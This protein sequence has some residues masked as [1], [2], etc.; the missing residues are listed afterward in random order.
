MILRVASAPLALASLARAAIFFDPAAVKHSCVNDD[1]TTLTPSVP[2]HLS[3]VD[4]TYSEQTILLKPI[5]PDA[6]I[7]D[8]G[9][10]VT[11]M[12]VLHRW[13][14]P[15]EDKAAKRGF[16]FP[17]GRSVP[18]VPGEVYGNY[19][20]S[21]GDWTR[22]PGRA[23]R[24]VEY[25]CGEAGNSGANFDAGEYLCEVTL[26][27]TSK[28]NAKDPTATDYNNAPY[29]LTYYQRDMTVRNE[30]ARFLEKNTFGPTEAEIDALEAEFQTLLAGAPA[31]SDP[32]ASPAGSPV[33][34]PAAA[35]ATDGPTGSPVAAAAAAATGSP[36]ASPV[37]TEATNTSRR[38]LQS[39]P[40]SHAEAMAQI[41]HNWISR[42][43]DPATF[44]S[45]EFSSLRAYWRRRLNAR[46]EETYRIGESGP[47]PCEA[48]SRWRKFAF[49]NFD[50]QNSKALRWG[51]SDI[52][53]A[54]QTQRGHRIT[55]ETV[56][57]WAPA[58][59]AVDLGA[60]ADGNGTN[61][62]FAPTLSPIMP[63]K[64]P[65][66]APVVPVPDATGSP[67]LSSMPTATPPPN[68]FAY[69]DM[70]GAQGTLNNQWPGR[71]ARTVTTNATG[72]V[73]EG[74]QSL[75][76]EGGTRCWY[77]RP[78]AT[79]CSAARV[80]DPIQFGDKLL[81]S[82]KIR[83]EN[84]ANQILQIYTA[85]YHLNKSPRRWALSTDDSYMVTR[86]QIPAADEWTTVTAVHTVGDDW[87]WNGEV[88]TPERCNHY[89]LRFRLSNSAASFY[90]DDV[91]VSK[92]GSSSSSDVSS[93]TETNATSANTTSE[94]IAETTA[95]TDV[96]VSTSGFFTN[97]N[98]DQG[99]QYWKYA[100]NAPTIR[101]DPD[102]NRNVMV[103]KRGRVLRQNVLPYT[104]PGKAYQFGFRS[105]I[106]G[107]DSVEMR[108]IVRMRFRNNDL[109]NGPC[110][111][112]VCNF[113]VRPLRR[114][115]RASDGWDDV[116]SQEFDM[117]NYTELEEYG[118]PDFIL[119]QL[120]AVNMDPAGELSVA[121]FEN[122]GDD[123]TD[124][125]SMSLAPSSA[126]SNLIQQ[127]IAYI[128]KYAGE[129]RTIVRAPFQMDNTGEVLA[130]DGSRE[131]QLCEV[132]EVEGLKAE[133]PNRMNF[134]INGRCSPI[135]G[136][137]PTVDLDPNFVNHTDL[138][139]LDLSGPNLT[140]D[141]I[142]ADQTYGGDWLL[143]T[144]VQDEAC[145]T[146]PSPY[147]NDYRGA[148]P[149]N[150][151][152][153]PTRFV[154]DKPV[155]AK[156]PDGTY[157]LYD[158]RLILHGNTLD[159][160][161]I[162][163]GGETVL[164]STIRSQRDGL[165]PLKYPWA[166]EYY[167]FNDQNIALCS[168]EQPNFI[169]Q[170]HCVV[171]YEENVCVKEYLD[172]SNTLV[173][174]QLVIKF[175]DGTL[176]NMHNATLVNY[177]ETTG[178]DNRR[179]F[180]A[181]SNLRWDDSVVNGNITVL[182]CVP[183]NPVSR[184]KPRPDL[185][186]SNC[187]N[188]LTDRSTAAFVHALESSNDENPY[189]RD[190][191]LWN[192]LDE[193]GCDEVD[194][195]KYGMLVMTNEGCW[196]NMHPDYMSIYDFTGYEDDHPVSTTGIAYINNWTAVGIMEYPD[197][198]PMSYFEQLK[199]AWGKILAVERY[200]YAS[201]SRV[202]QGA[203][204]GDTIV[205]DQFAD[206]ANLNGD[207]EILMEI[208]Q[209]IAHMTLANKVATNRGGGTLVCGSPNEVAP[210]PTLDDYFDVIHRDLDCIGCQD[211]YGDYAKQKVTVWTMDA[212]EGEDQLCGR[213]AWSL[214]ELLNVGSASNPDNT[215]SNLYTYDI[216]RRHCF[217]S[218]FDLLKELTF[219]SKTGEQFSFVGSTATRLSWDT[220][221][222]MNFPDENY[223]REI[224]QL[225][226][227]G[228]HEL[229]QDGTETRDEHGRVIKTYTN[230]DILSNARVMTG[231]MF[232]ARRGN[233]E[234]LFR[235]EKSRLDPLRIEVDSH[236]FFPKPAL[237]GGWIGDRYPLC[238]DLPEHHFL[239]LGAKY[240][241]R[242]SSSLPRVHY[243]PFHWDSDESIK[244]FVLDPSSGL[245]QAL[246]NAGDDGV[247]DYSTTVTLDANLQC[248]GKECRVDDLMVVQ[249]APGAFYEY[250]RQPCVQLSFYENPK[251]VITGFSP[252]IR[253]VGRRHTH[254]MCADPR[255]AVAARAC[256]DVAA[257]SRA[258]YN[259]DF[260]YHGERVKL[261][262]NLDQCMADNGTVCDPVAMKADNPLVN[263]RPTYNLPYPSQNTFFW[264][265][266]NCTQ[267]VKVRDG[268]M[269][270]IVNDPARNP[271]F[272]EDT[273]PFVDLINT[274]NYFSVIW[275][276]DNMTFEEIYPSLN[277]TCGGGACSI[278]SDDACEC[279]VTLV[280]SPAFNSLPSREG[281]LSLK[282]G[283]YD[284]ATFSAE[285]VTYSLL[286]SSDDVEAYV[287][288]DSVVI[289]ATS[290]IF[291]VVDEFGEVA[292]FKNMLSTITLGGLYEL[293][294]P[295]SFMNLVKVELRDAEYEV[296]AFLK[297]L[298]QYRSSAPFI[299]KKLIQYHGISNPSPG[300]AQRITQAFVTGSYSSNGV[301][302]GNGKFGSLKAVAAAIALDPESL[303]PVID[304]DPVSGNIR[305][306]LLKVIHF[307]RS[308][309]FQRRPHVKFRHGLFDNM[310]YKVGQLVFDPPD[311]F[312]FFA[313][314][315][316]PPGVLAETDM[317]SPESELMSMSSVVGLTTGLFSFVNY[318]LAHA[319]G[320]FGPSLNKLPDVGD[321]SASMG[322]ITYPY[323]PNNV[324]NVTSKI[325]ELSTLMTSGRLS[326]ENKQVM[327][328]AH[329]YFT[330]TH[331]VDFADRV[332][333]KLLT[334][335]PEFHTSNT[336][337]KTGAP[338]PI[339]P[340]ATKSSSPYKA[341][342]YINLAGGAD[343]F[344]ILTPGTSGCASLYDEYFEARGKGAGI[345]LTT[346]EILNIDGSSAGIDGCS[347]LGVNSMLS[348][349]KDIFDEGK[350]IFFANMGHL[351]KPVAKE[352]W[353]VET[354]TDLFSH[355]AMKLESHVVDA[356]REGEGPGVMGRMLDI[357]ERHG[358]AVG[359]TAVGGRAPMIDGSPST[360]RLA[361][362]MS[363]DGVPRMFDRNFLRGSDNQHLRPYLESMHAETDDS[364]G[365][366]GNAY[367]QAFVDIWN[368]TDALVGTLRAT[369]LATS[370]ASPAATNVGG[371]T[372]QLK[373]IAKLI[374]IR[375]E[376]GNGI[377]RDVFYCEMGG[378]DSHFQLASV[379]ENKLPSLNHA[380]ATFW[381]EMK[382]QGLENNVVVIQGSEFGR[383]ITPNSNAGSDH[384]WGGNYFMFGGDVKGGK[385]KGDYP[386]SFGA[387]DPIN[388]GRGRLLP[389][390]S[391]D[392]L[393]YG[394]T[395]WM[396]ITDQD[397]IDYVL[398]NAP[399][400][401]CN[402]FT[403]YDLFNT[404][405]Q[406]LNGCGGVT[407]TAPITF[408]VPEIRQLTGEE[409]K[410][411]CLLATRTASIQFNFERFKSR[412]YVADQTITE[413]EIAL[414]MYDVNG[415]AVLNF[416]GTLPV[417]TIS[418]ETVAEAATGISK[419]ASATASDFVV[420]GAL[421]QSEAPSQMPS[422]QPSVSAE[423]SMSPSIS[424]M[425]SD[426]PSEVPSN[427]P[428]VS[429]APSFEPSVSLE[430]TGRPS[431]QP[432]VTQAPSL[433]PS[434]SIA[435]SFSQEPTPAPTAR[436]VFEE[437]FLSRDIGYV[438]I[439]GQSIEA[440]S[441]LYMVQGS[442]WDIWDSNDK[443]HYMYI[444][445]SGDATFTVLSESFQ[446][447]HEWS[448]AGIMFRSSLSTYSTHY[449]LFG[450]GS[451][452]VRNVYRTCFGCSS[453]VESGTAHFSSVWLRV[454]KQ[455]NVM[456]SFYKPTW[457]EH[458]IPI[459]LVTSL[460][461]ISSNGYYIGI[462][463]TSGTNSGVAT[464]DVSNIQLARTCSSE[465]ITQLQCD[466]AS[467][468]ESGSVSGS[469]YNKDE[470]P[471][472]E[473]A[474]P[475]SNIID[476]GA[477]VTTFGC[478]D[479]TGAANRAV[480]GTTHK[481]FCNRNET[482]LGVPTGL[483]LKPH[484]QR[485]STAVGLRLYAPNNAPHS[486]PVSYIFEGRTDSES[487]W[488]LIG[489]GDFPWKSGLTTRNA[490]LGLDISSTYARGDATYVF[491]EVS[492]NDGDPTHLIQYKEYKITWTAQRDPSNLSWQV[493]ELEVPGLLG[494]APAMPVLDY[495]GDYVASIMQGGN[496]DI[497]LLYGYN[498]GTALTQQMFD[499]S[500]N[501]FFMYRDG[502][503]YKPGMQIS[504]SH[505]RLSVLTGLRFYMANNNPGA[506]P[507]R[508]RVKGRAMA[509]ANVKTRHDNTS[510][511]KFNGSY[512]TLVSSCS[513]TSNDQRF[514]MN[515]IGEIRVKSNPGYCI[516]VR[517]GMEGSSDRKGYM[518]SCI[519]DT[520]GQEHG[521][522]IYQRFTYDSTTENIKSV[523]QTDQCLDLHMDYFFLYVHSCHGGNNQKFFFPSGLFQSGTG[524]D[525]DWTLI[526]QGSLP[527]ISEF[528]RNPSGVAISSTYESGDP[529]KYFMEVN[530]HE[531]TT[532][533]YEYRF[534]F[535]ETRNPD[536]T[537][538]QFSELEL[539]G[540]LLPVNWQVGDTSGIELANAPT[541]QECK[542]FKVDLLTDYYP[543]EIAWTVT[544]DCGLPET[545]SS[546][547]Y[548]S[549]ITHH[550]DTYCLQPSRYTW[551][552]TDSAHDGICCGYGI[553]NYHLY[554]DG[555]LTKSGGDYGYSDTHSFGNC[556]TEPAPT[557]PPTPP[558]TA[559]FFADNTE[560]KAAVDACYGDTKVEAE[561]NAV[562]AE[563]GPIGEWKVGEVTDM[564]Y[565]FANKQDFNVDISLGDTSSTTV[566]LGM[567]LNS[568]FN[569]PL[570]SWNTSSVISLRDMFVDNTVFNQDL[571]N[572]DTSNVATTGVGRMFMRATAFNGQ[573]NDWDTSKVTKMHYM[574]YGAWAFNQPLN[575]WDTS[576][577]DDMASM[578]NDARAFNQPLS[579]WDVSIVTNMAAMFYQT[580]AFNQRLNDWNVAQ[581]TNMW[582]TF[583]YA[584]A[585]NQYL[586]WDVT[587]KDTSQLF[588]GSGGGS[589]DCVVSNPSME[590]VLAEEWVDNGFTLSRS[591][592]EKRSG[593]WSL[594][595]TGRTQSWHG[596]KQALDLNI[597]VPLQYYHVSCWVKSVATTST[598][599]VIF[600]V[601]N[602]T[603]TQYVGSWT[604]PINS[605]SWTLI[606]RDD[607]MITLGAPLTGVNLGIIGPPA[608]ESFYVD[609]CYVSPSAV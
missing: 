456:R 57:Y 258:E 129:V 580:L 382:A 335:A 131:Y 279:S 47:H 139:L 517:N 597:M 107:T 214:Y 607:V 494:E 593:S 87:K 570:N 227:T 19:T 360:G 49:T 277:N 220:T 505:G 127:H 393:F 282:I 386:R 474:E 571:N 235:S 31:T 443:F 119:F 509:G 573:L 112:A 185:D 178:V 337:R 63:T 404:G 276:R 66:G 189:L 300:F 105:K 418:E 219:N 76:F 392:A 316:A 451:N 399:N 447:N 198:H 590:D 506:D 296:D 322:F 416:D 53:G 526:S 228:L 542:E 488:V 329:A 261:S 21:A 278:T 264:T 11:S 241:F 205:L 438:G 550:S 179:Y 477:Y 163:G 324:T 288:S 243:N 152:D 489:Q 37:A 104:V 596:P 51:T 39:I 245:Y 34:T 480:D 142:N 135:R 520:E 286:E 176:A 552:I 492:F 372:S 384:A 558:P 207:P 168:N 137:N 527:W 18:E 248:Y 602:G 357:L 225:Y 293:R 455:G 584:S 86:F 111:R 75:K 460:S 473:S 254:A 149:E 118:E 274:V 501:K 125:P 472:W 45:G 60:L 493:S 269:I 539:P 431:A 64:A 294:N 325:D 154:P 253:Q 376:R 349:Y 113:N 591:S 94:A 146:F 592:S 540:L 461:S 421:P 545:V 491:T 424:T 414:G 339:T 215:E 323:Q 317:V 320:G 40:P 561:C 388:I 557:P 389:T 434:V 422:S 7:N 101:M 299:T 544:N 508:Y 587:G 92:I 242:G 566:M 166:E 408:Q 429:T 246:C 367:S 463:V 28:A 342:V 371:I 405:Q 191:Y 315:Y 464:L 518:V 403:D 109:E 347:T 72:P 256:C 260:E 529:D 524:T 59:E 2:S 589:A 560:L 250:I 475:V 239:K 159:S 369:S 569:Q 327:V 130:M 397:E 346:S 195:D 398:P 379:F 67:T 409:Q 535:L 302:Y 71:C 24:Q 134:F 200:S 234:E 605:S 311:Q 352:N 502:W 138:H 285:N 133:F 289:G 197:S 465:T 470:V 350:G 606:G 308:L 608:G 334:A 565:L 466:Q 368:K 598:A 123:Y 267:T 65:T 445:T 162:D 192:D 283:A 240:R 58:E 30:I 295:P 100:R 77:F 555:S 417:E 363:V 5:A 13:T 548:S 17:L 32:T 362:I 85:H 479:N 564:R 265:D 383:T 68:I 338:R 381:A 117:F 259:Y 400:H 484:H 563:Y 512:I 498:S 478:N 140:V 458:W 562:T 80:T 433:A 452:G 81:I 22:P 546:P 437:D 516:D 572:W 208:A 326:P 36:T 453:H 595:A 233:V 181:V 387:S 151:D 157:A 449:S 487:S 594:Y 160:P 212:L 98:F 406:I 122:F 84:M 292:F 29:F 44:S 490:G 585:F 145:A 217:G 419:A 297:H 97:P 237:G 511:W 312:S 136:G 601:D 222:A 211:S 170:D 275:Q 496:V 50:V 483:V 27:T 333:L 153:I 41:Q 495:P 467:N 147:D 251:K 396:G 190:I 247:C 430:P 543:W 173:D 497:S 287:A 103:V 354:R 356:F 365:V 156:L 476:V 82:F 43:M 284:P 23:S 401:G 309:S 16:Y 193:D 4:T 12:C 435:P 385:I 305:E 56:E 15:M 457:Y 442:G 436:K 345:G 537:M 462:A 599:D 531:N 194:Y 196:E 330:E 226:T 69:G 249:V 78:I 394:L 210:D 395:Q 33:E 541:T 175:D 257:N 252:W 581:V 439:V 504:P 216:F 124:A 574:F 83:V 528:D 454:T 348:A 304:E 70:E 499:G 366:F 559:P 26:P 224:M 373:L 503:E 38:V 61:G 586:C 519:S 232:T 79:S 440:A 244:R 411:V 204:Y 549:Q 328:D 55:V 510:C 262:T 427:V 410:Q 203:R 471:P 568:S 62:T 415:Y 25:V 268:G 8:A 336:L 20:G 355:H 291:K 603:D 402:L 310:A 364:S 298:I 374:N 578:F 507:M 361:D 99:Y 164:R 231:F 121:S 554:W 280:E 370:F 91:R 141:V 54:Y 35:A 351:H 102:I 514:Y 188:D 9:D 536:S 412:C 290:T 515:E 90:L 46:K 187:V 161:V 448:K 263:I 425:P 321:Y 340:P 174:V 600:R 450:T 307:M 468:C 201:T 14:L 441:G 209:N 42:Q 218:Y 551:T 313:S 358:H 272:F 391:W 525:L 553:G 116:I 88:L 532:P 108:I 567:F 74:E 377:N 110:P 3:D 273:V 314:D 52:G 229:N 331:G 10:G 481:V 306:P 230:L 556:V 238:T 95:P 144:P 459:G 171:S 530:F 533:Y 1:G 199:E 344:N 420:S 165:K 341:I 114:T 303:S 6:V 577:V 428:S 223:G 281:V 167:I 380:V 521:D 522:V 538:T 588:D 143:E 184:W 169:N 128:V 446:N 523:W 343:S 469:C 236:D 172:S 485:M 576:K 158:S 375:N 270:A 213:M 513:T 115:I 89:H 575:N 73:Y 579:E 182:P 482:L 301:T 500:T 186:N 96:V 432:S 426:L 604:Q 318:G 583:F 413:S 255:T 547:A 106:T 582:R 132:D 177:N 319:D 332:L 609:D 359:A 486:D 180:Y 155:F 407:H 183:E 353:L 93:Q 378:Y 48:H 444:E 266:A 202:N 271:W 423:P 206:Q 150:P 390:T 148:D 120:F 534:V 221:G 126:P